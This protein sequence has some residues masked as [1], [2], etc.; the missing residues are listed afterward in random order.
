M[1][2][3]L[4]FKDSSPPIFTGSAQTK[5]EIKLALTN[6]LLKLP[7]GLPQVSAALKMVDIIG[8][9]L[10]IEGLANSGKFYFIGDDFIC[11][12]MVSGDSHSDTFSWD[13]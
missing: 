2:R 13:I 1:P 5:V 9:Y 7:C 6:H 12:R 3:T 4:L 8:D 11:D 10:N